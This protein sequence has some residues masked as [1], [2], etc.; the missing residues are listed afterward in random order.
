VITRPADRADRLVRRLRPFGFQFV[1]APLIE[2]EPIETGPIDLSHYDWVVLTSAR[3]ASELRSRFTG[4]VPRV[5]AIGKAT[6]EAWGKKVDLVAAVSTQEGL[7][8]ELPRPAGRVLFAGAEDARRLLV[9]ELQADFVP[10][11]RT[12]RIVPKEPI[13]GD[14]VIL[15]SASAARAYGDLGLNIPAVTIGPETTSAAEESGVRVLREAQTHDL[16][17]LVHAVLKATR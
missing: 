12:N 4:D 11:Y 16:D 1:V 15:A 3:G 2:L 9:E 10:L 5:A 14:L 17:G 8:A 13:H 6:A 7:L